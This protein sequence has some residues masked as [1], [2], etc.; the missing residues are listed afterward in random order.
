MVWKWIDLVLLGFDGIAFLL[1]GVDK[2]HAMRHRRRISEAVLL[3]IGF[4]GGAFG[5]L[6][7]MLLFRHKTRHW[8]FWLLNGLGMLWKTVLIFWLTEQGLF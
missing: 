5:A 2:F 1:Y 7:G 4:F 6:L 3:E 8:Y